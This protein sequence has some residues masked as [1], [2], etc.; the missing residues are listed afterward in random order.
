MRWIRKR[1]KNLCSPFLFFKQCIFCTASTE[2]EQKRKK[3]MRKKKKHVETEH[4]SG[5]EVEREGPGE[6]KDKPSLQEELYL[7]GH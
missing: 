2:S 6:E 1:G 3:W 7:L 4:Q 5:D